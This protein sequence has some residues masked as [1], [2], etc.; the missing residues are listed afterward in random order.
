VLHQ[1]IIQVIAII[2][3]NWRLEAISK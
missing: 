1:G 3:I 2:T